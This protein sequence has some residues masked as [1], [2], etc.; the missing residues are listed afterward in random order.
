MD[1]STKVTL[2]AIEY[3][4]HCLSKLSE[5]TSEDAKIGKFIEAYKK[6]ITIIPTLDPPPSPT[7]TAGS[8]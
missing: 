7:R 3:A 1:E 6:A 8:L 2:L 5:D 4:G